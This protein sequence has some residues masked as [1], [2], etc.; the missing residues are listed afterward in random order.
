MLDNIYFFLLTLKEIKILWRTLKSIMG[1]RVSLLCVFI[2]EPGSLHVLATHSVHHFG[3]QAVLL[4][5]CNRA[6]SGK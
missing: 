5:G 3:A 4:L 6:A 1:T 2:K